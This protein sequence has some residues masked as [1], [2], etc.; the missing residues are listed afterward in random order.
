MQVV[1]IYSLQAASYT[2]ANSDEVTTRFI[3]DSILYFFM[4]CLQ[5]AH[6]KL[7]LLQTM[8]R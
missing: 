5:K 4:D 6:K 7:S 2:Y 3:V 8:E 1:D